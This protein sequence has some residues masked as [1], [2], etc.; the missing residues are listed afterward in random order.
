MTTYNQLIADVLLELNR[1]D[2]DTV[3]AIPRMIS[4]AQN[5]LSDK[6]NNLGYV[7]YV[8]GVFIPGQNLYEKPGRWRAW[9]TFNFGSGAGNNTKTILELKVMEYLT[10][11]WPDATQLDAPR[12]Y[13][14]Y[15]YTNFKVA[16]TPDE[17]YPFELG[18]T[19]LPQPLSI[20]SQTN[21][22]TDFAPTLLFYATLLQTPGFLR[23]PERYAE[24]RAYFDENLEAINRRDSTRK[25]DRGVERAA[26]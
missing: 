14:D 11:Y 13:A 24:W 16:P 1:N 23:D 26:D 3:A 19:E 15:G 8:N 25:F 12:F 6:I 20:I 2:A 9:E 7:Q 10:T 21:W 22:F 5:V 18:Y 4:D 17:A